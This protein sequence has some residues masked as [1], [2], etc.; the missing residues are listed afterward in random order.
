[1]AYRSNGQFT[2]V[3]CRWS[4]GVAKFYERA[5][6][7][8]KKGQGTF[9]FTGGRSD[10]PTAP[11]SAEFSDLRDLPE[12]TVKDVEAKAKAYRSLRK[13]DAFLRARMGCNLY[14]AAFLLPKTDEVP[15]G[16]SERTVPTSQDVWLAVGQ[17]KPTRHGTQHPATGCPRTR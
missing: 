16:D 8:A 17:G 11:L 3:A 10:L 9:D 7:D 1:M 13:Q 2:V 4:C 12:D 5:N 15:S 14:M 6:K